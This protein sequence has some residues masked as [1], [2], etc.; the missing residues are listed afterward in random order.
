MREVLKKELQTYNAK[1]SSLI[2]KAKGKFVE[3]SPLLI[4]RY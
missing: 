1:K 4:N 3:D 2:G